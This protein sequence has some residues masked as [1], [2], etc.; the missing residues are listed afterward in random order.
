MTSNNE[1]ALRTLLQNLRCREVRDLAYACFG[2]PMITSLK[3]PSVCYQALLDDKTKQRLLALDHEPAPL[4]NFIAQVTSTR[5]G[6]YFETLWRFYWLHLSTKETL[7]AHNLQ[8]NRDGKTLGAYDFIVKR[9]AHVWHI[10]AALKFYLGV[11]NHL[12]CADH[13]L[14]PN[15]SDNLANKINHLRMHQL[16]L[17]NT[18]EGLTTLKAAA[19]PVTGTQFL[20][21]G[22]LFAPRAAE[23]TLPPGVNPEAVQGYWYHLNRLVG[24]LTNTLT[25]NYCIV[26]RNHWLAPIVHHHAVRPLGCS[27]LIKALTAQL[28]RQGRPK[29]VAK[30]RL[31]KGVWREQERFF[32]VPNHW[33]GTASP[34]FNT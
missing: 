3:H 15:T 19:R 29:M 16:N 13:W 30:L 11:G 2:P 14:G 31:D 27:Q 34:S 12:Q 17:S 33:P 5:L 20:L 7:L 32:V 4:L 1:A 10:E 25:A 8:V 24:S 23:W 26:P 18:P 22:Y 28:N 6:V 9:D 21:K